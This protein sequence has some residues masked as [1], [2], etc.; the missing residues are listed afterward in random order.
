MR[1]S[2]STGTE[3]RSSTPSA[4]S[5]G[6]TIAAERSGCGAG[7]PSGAATTRPVY[8]FDYAVE[9][10][11]LEVP[12]AEDPRRELVTVSAGMDQRALTRRADGIFPPIIVS[13]WMTSGAQELTSRSHL[14]AL[15]APYAKPGPIRAG[16]DYSL[17]R[18]RIEQAYEL[19]PAG[20]WGESW[21]S[22]EGAAQRLVRS[23]E[24]VRAAVERATAIANRDSATRLSQLRLRAMRT[25]G[26]ELV[27]LEEELHREEVIARAMSAAVA[28]PS[29]RLDSTG[30]VVLSGR[31]LTS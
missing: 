8:R 3:T 9:A 18:V 13:V 5:S 22:A 28:A 23:R 21:R 20:N 30:I 17:N 12:S 14:D 19:I 11:P 31:A 25:T 16:G 6:T 4:I 1:T 29:L 10:D 27:R 7:C 24:D 26:S 2:T 15:S